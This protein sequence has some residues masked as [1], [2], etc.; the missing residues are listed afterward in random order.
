MKKVIFI[1]AACAFMT[2]CQWWHQT[3]SSP[4][5][6]AIW[7]CEQADKAEEAGDE[8]KAEELEEAFREWING[9][10]E[11]EQDQVMEALAEWQM[12]KWKESQR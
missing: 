6:C 4:G 1:L 12:A 10:T 5:K 3:I 7:Y 11:E 8:E 2:S 9:L